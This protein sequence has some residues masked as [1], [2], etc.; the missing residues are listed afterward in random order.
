MEVIENLPQFNRFIRQN[1]ELFN[2]LTPDQKASFFVRAVETYD[3]TKGLFNALFDTVP[4]PDDAVQLV[5]NVDLSLMN[6]TRLF[7]ALVRLFGDLKVNYFK[8]SFLKYLQFRDDL[9]NT[10][11]YDDIFRRYTEQNGADG[12]LKL[13]TQYIFDDFENGQQLH[14]GLIYLEDLL[15]YY[16]KE[17]VTLSPQTIDFIVD[18]ILKFEKDHPNQIVEQLTSIFKIIMLLSDF[19]GTMSNKAMLFAVRHGAK[20]V[21]QKLVESKYPFF[22]ESPDNKI[23]D[24]LG[25]G[26]EQNAFTNVRDVDTFD[27]LMQYVK[28][29]PQ[30]GDVIN[31][32]YEDGGHAISSL[33]DKNKDDL[34][35]TNSF[36]DNGA[37]FTAEDIYRAFKQQKLE[38]IRM[39][40]YR[41]MDPYGLNYFNKTLRNMDRSEYDKYRRH[42]ATVSKKL[43]MLKP[44]KETGK[45]LG[46]SLLNWIVQNNVAC[47]DKVEFIVNLISF[48]G[49]TGFDIDPEQLRKTKGACD[50][51]K[52]VTARKN[53]EINRLEAEDK[54]SYAT[55]LIP[56]APREIAPIIK[57]LAR[58]KE[59][60]DDLNNVFD[61]AELI[62]LYQYLSNEVVDNRTLKKSKSELC[63][64]IEQM[65]LSKLSQP[66]SPTM[67][68]VM[69]ESGSD[70][71][72]KAIRERSFNSVKRL[73]EDGVDVNAPGFYEYDGKR[74]KT[75][76]LN[77][78]VNWDEREIAEYLL[79]HGADMFLETGGAS[80]VLQN[81]L[82]RSPMNLKDYVK[83]ED[84][85][86][87]MKDFAIFTVLTAPGAM[88]L[89]AS[90]YL[91]SDYPDVNLDK[92]YT[93]D[94]SK[95]SLRD[96]MLRSHYTDMQGDP[97]SLTDQVELQKLVKEYDARMEQKKRR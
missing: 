27:I 58:Q 36:L 8:P 67:S 13:L 45:S 33:P 88:L 73:V 93:I 62:A 87:Y 1:G 28:Q 25:D 74:F 96:Q 81:L 15:N 55:H 54:L 17:K 14:N 72:V 34:D 77:V 61:K 21:L 76:P 95:T 94:D 32:T 41:F 7:K 6:Q 12:L 9:S 60:C 51:F 40:L 43:Q 91:L 79:E 2:R 69:K 70:L 90:K 24:A 68:P 39:V 38:L 53:L 83:P 44:L 29:N 65:V 30:L 46:A 89:G 19:S 5:Q 18:T 71:M 59:L 66:G 11:I 31:R 52:G 20:R 80:I 47:S 86:R 3:N 22:V 10:L 78:A 63:K 23:G 84:M 92:L 16:K 42:V 75:Y 49:G 4:L 26:V 85:G 82:T 37:L 50:L 97:P 35:I 64:D 57:L 48:L 56:G